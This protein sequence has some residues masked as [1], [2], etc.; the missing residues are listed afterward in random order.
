M[1]QANEIKRDATILFYPH[2]Q[3]FFTK[4]KNS[5][6]QSRLLGSEV[7][8]MSE[9]FSSSSRNLARRRNRRKCDKPN[10]GETKQV[11]ENHSHPHRHAHPRLI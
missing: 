3:K 9:I 5:E 6:A 8:D 11:P 4:K 10:S 2:G 7:V 1:E